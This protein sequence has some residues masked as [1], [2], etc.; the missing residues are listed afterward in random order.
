LTKDDTPYQRFVRILS[1]A[2]SGKVVIKELE[3]AAF[4]W[5]HS[6][7]SKAKIC[8]IDHT[9]PVEIRYILAMYQEATERREMSLQNG[10]DPITLSGTVVCPFCN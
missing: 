6:V 2:C 4:D 3:G 5:L 10:S 9:C 7:D 8:L 1:F